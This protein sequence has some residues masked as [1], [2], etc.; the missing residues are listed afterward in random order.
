MSDINQIVDS[1][2]S[3]CC[4]ARSYNVGKMVFK[5]SICNNNVTYDF[6]IALKSQV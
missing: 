3:Y 2:K 1:Y 5:C 6:F 4:N